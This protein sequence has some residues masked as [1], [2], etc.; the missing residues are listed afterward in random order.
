MRVEATLIQRTTETADTKGDGTIMT[1]LKVWTGLFGKRYRKRTM[2]GVLMMA[3][4][5]KGGFTYSS[6]PTNVHP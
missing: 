4:Q 3:F 2:V 1:E 5:R 6:T